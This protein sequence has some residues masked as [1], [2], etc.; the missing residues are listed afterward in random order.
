MDKS[1]KATGSIQAWISICLRH[2]VRPK[3][4]LGAEKDDGK[5]RTA[6]GPHGFATESVKK[7]GEPPGQGGCAF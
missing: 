7:S 5:P 3:A 6:S 4:F 2:P 1:E